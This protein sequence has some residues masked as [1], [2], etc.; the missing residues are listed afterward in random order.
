[1][2]LRRLCTIVAMGVLVAT[3]AP[4]G[5]ALPSDGYFD[6]ANVPGEIKVNQGDQI[7]PE[8]SRYGHSY[9]TVGYVD[10][11]NGRVWL[12]GHCGAD[13]AKVYDKHKREIGTLKQRYDKELTEGQWPRGHHNFRANDLAYVQLADKNFAGKNVFSGNQI[14]QPQ[15]GDTVCYY[16]AASKKTSCSE[17]LNTDSYLTVTG[18]LGTI[19]G[20]SGGPNWVP[21]KGYVGQTLGS[22]SWE[23]TGASV[24][25]IR[26]QDVDMTSLAIPWQQDYE[27]SFPTPEEAKQVQK[28][29][30]LL[31]M[32]YQGTRQREE[33][34]AWKFDKYLSDLGYAEEKAALREA[35]Q[36]HKAALVNVLESNPWDGDNAGRVSFLTAVTKVTALGEEINQLIEEKSTT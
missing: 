25:I 2:V 21:G 24:S 7:H 11:E 3:G 26:N 34:N 16:G 12:A 1:M 15:K 27:F 9:C 8:N 28:A 5:H 20:D 4:S 19:S 6:T 22:L 29:E 31:P 33:N 10:V 30:V 36:Q 13:G 23:N 35:V 17:V 32:I 18:Q 14:Y